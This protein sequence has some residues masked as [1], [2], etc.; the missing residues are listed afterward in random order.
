[1]LSTDLG[2]TAR[3]EPS[4][5]ER[6]DLGHVVETMSRG[7]WILIWGHRQPQLHPTD[8]APIPP[9]HLS[10]LTGGCGRRRHRRHAPQHHDP[11]FPQDHPEQDA[12][13]DPDDG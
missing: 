3:G 9:V 11:T 5:V 7:R 10:E 13:T 8:V 1:M 6:S 12:E 2:T 4:V